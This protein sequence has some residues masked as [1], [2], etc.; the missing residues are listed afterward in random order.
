M[1]PLNDDELTALLQQAKAKPLRPSSELSARTMQA[2]HRSA[3][4]PGTVRRLLFRPVSS[5]L[6][7]A[8]LAAALLIL[9]GAVGDRVLRA[10]SVIVRSR[11]VEVPVVHERVVYRGCPAETTS[12][13]PLIATPTFREMRPVRQIRPRV[14]RSIRDDQ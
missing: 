7:F 1:N 14:V 12:S 11:S 6:A 8:A 9:I 5:P 2:Y 13:S 10:P 3:A 4:G